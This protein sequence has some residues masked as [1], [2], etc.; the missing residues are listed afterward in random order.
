MKEAILFLPILIP[1]G[2]AILHLFLWKQILAQRV[3][4]IISSLIAAI[5]TSILFFSSEYSGIITIQAGNWIPP[6]GISLVADQLTKL[7]LIL[8]SFVGLSISIF[9]FV[10]IGEGRVKYGFYP[11]F[12]FLIMGLSGAFLTGDIF[13]LYVWFEIVIISS[14]VLVSLGADR[15][16]LQASIPYVSMNLLASIIFLTGIGILY[17]LTGSLNMADLSIQVAKVE[18]RSL[19]QITA[20]FFIVGFGMKS[21]VFPLYFWLPSS[22]H[23]PP[24]AIT[25]AFGGLLTK[26]GIYALIRTF[27]L[28]FIPDTAISSLL[29]WIAI[30]TLVTGS[31]GA[32]IQT[33]LRKMFSYLIVCH[34][35]FMIAGLSLFTDHS[36]TGSIYY[37]LHDIP[38]KANLFLIAGLIIRMNGSSYYK[39]MGGIQKAYPALSF[40]IALAVLSVAGIPPLSGFFPKL[41]L[42]KSSLL[43]SIPLAITIIF[44]SFITLYAVSRM[45]KEVFW[46]DAVSPPNIN[47]TNKQWIFSMIPILALLLLSLSIGLYAEFF[48]QIASQV[49]EELLHPNLYI[50][51]VFGKGLIQ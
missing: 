16:R 28:I 15:V 51:A 47:F 12:H 36:L 11:S 21:A 43:L 13:N 3:I 5:I 1:L 41:Y 8:T 18:E 50:Q 32:L 29:E 26:L 40:I 20:V 45:W 31:L 49:S 2:A 46:K 23:T 10:G 27:T 22:Y 25:A 6:F 48:I 42:L 34:I 39:D 14:F 38:A 37:L 4:S 33:N 17:G 7:M 35:G 9:S 30:L 19:V 44:A 24:S